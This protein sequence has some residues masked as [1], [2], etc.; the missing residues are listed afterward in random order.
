MNK[1]LTGGLLFLL[2]SGSFVSGSLFGPFGPF[3]AAGQL[4]GALPPGFGGGVGGYPGVGGLPLYPGRPGVG[5]LPMFPAPGLF[6]SVPY[7]PVGVPPTPVAGPLAF[8]RMA[9]ALSPVAPTPMVPAAATGNLRNVATNADVLGR[10]AVADL[11]EDLQQRAK[12]LQA[13]SDQ[14]FDACEQM[15]ATPGAYWQY[16]RCN[17]LQL[18]TVLTAAKALEQEATARA[19]AAAAAAA[20]Q[21]QPAES[22]PATV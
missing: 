8:G 13:A 7:L 21:P 5:Q 3:G 4:P 22:A 16:K 14:G 6:P 10:L 9:M 15:L 17:A 19:T 20:E 11:P 2:V 18:R 1:L 12:D